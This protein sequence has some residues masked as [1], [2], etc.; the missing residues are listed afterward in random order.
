MVNSYYAKLSK[1]FKLEIVCWEEMFDSRQSD[2]G[3]WENCALIKMGDK[4]LRHLSRSDLVDITYELQK[5]DLEK[6][7][8]LGSKITSLK[9]VL[10]S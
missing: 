3:K 5:Q 6:N 8:L 9:R 2:W 10:I 4:E 7:F 1:T